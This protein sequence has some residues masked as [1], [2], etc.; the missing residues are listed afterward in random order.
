MIFGRTI[1]K[2]VEKNSQVFGRDYRLTEFPGP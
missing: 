2:T 1:C